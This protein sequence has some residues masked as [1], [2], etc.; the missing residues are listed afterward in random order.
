MKI[1]SK[2]LIVAAA[3]VAL[4]P[5]SA[6]AASMCSVAPAAATDENAQGVSRADV[7]YNGSASDA[8]YGIIE[9]NDMVGGGVGSWD[10]NTLPIFGGGW[11]RFLRDDIEG[12]GAG[13][14]TS[15]NYLGST[16]T[17]DA[18][19]GS[20]GTWSIVVNPAI[21]PVIFQDILV[22]IKSGSQIQTNGATGG[23]AAYLFNSESFGGGAAGTFSVPMVNRN[24]VP[25]DIS[26]MSV[27]F[28]DG[29]EGCVGIPGCDPGDPA[30]E[31]ATMALVG[32]GLIGA[33]L[34]R[35]R[36]Q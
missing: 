15:F 16:W 6:R 25:R 5:T 18:S 20:S 4:M 35:R 21:M 23:W 29:D 8:C 10:V 30:P 13:S 12:G 1:F 7:S 19:A 2:L 36:K 34:A 3:T 33:G 17:L 27:Y 9:G 14:T 26:H 32:L 11:D 31:P 22:V 24:G 28:R